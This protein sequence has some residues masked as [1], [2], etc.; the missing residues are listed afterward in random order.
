MADPLGTVASLLTV[1]KLA[2]A[3]TKYIKDV[4]HGSAERLRLRDELRSTTCLLEMLK[5]RI[6]DSENGVEV[7]I[8]K[9]P[10]IASL[11]GEDGPLALF[12]Q[13]LEEIA[14]KLAPDAKRSR[15]T[16]PFT[17]PFDKKDIAEFVSTLERLKN[18]F[19]LVMQNDL[20]YV[21]RLRCLSALTL[22]QWPCCTIKPETRRYQPANRE[23]GKKI[24]RQRG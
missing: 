8:L 10:S 4:K 16:Q 7:E 3:A 6:D 19:S 18:H 5:D 14:A 21:A 17:W 24:T 15:L 20:V 23:C 12:K 2:A 11:A 22:L 9:L 13:L 1:L